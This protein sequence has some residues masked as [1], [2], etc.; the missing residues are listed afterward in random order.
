MPSWIVYALLSALFAAL[1][2][3]FAKAGLKDVNPDLATAIRTVIILIFTWGFVFFKGAQKE[4]ALSRGNWTFLVLSGIATGL[5]WIFYYRAL[6]LGK[7]A[8]VSIID[9]GSIAITILL[10][11]LFLREPLTLRVAAGACLV[12][13]G[14]VIAV[15]K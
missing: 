8:E 1:T 9:K 14:M 13:A 15:W 3:I 12:V 7:V 10:A 4:M 11:F 5:S 2:T 6:Q